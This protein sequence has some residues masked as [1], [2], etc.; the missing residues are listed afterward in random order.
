MPLPIIKRSQLTRELTCQEH[1]ANIDGLLDRGN[2]TGLQAAAT[3]FDLNTTV[4]AFDYIVALEEC[5]TT[6]TNRLTT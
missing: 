6:L 4:H 3:I 2:H 5:C 1:D